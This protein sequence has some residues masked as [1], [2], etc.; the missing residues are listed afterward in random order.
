MD[1]IAST[2]GAGNV[3]DGI[4]TETTGTVLAI[5]ATCGKESLCADKHVTVYKHALPGKYLLPAHLHDGGMALKWFKDQFCAAEQSL[6]KERGLPV[7]RL[8]DELAEQSR[9]SRT[10]F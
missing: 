1:Q 4:I 2:L 5:A 3:A 7:Y 10:A 9:P 8:L 6:A